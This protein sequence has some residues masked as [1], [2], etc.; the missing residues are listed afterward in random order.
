MNFQLTRHSDNKLYLGIIEAKIEE[1]YG[2][3]LICV[4]PYSVKSL[5]KAVLDKAKIL[6]ANAYEFCGAKL[7]DWSGEYCGSYSFYKIDKP[8]LKKRRDGQFEFNFT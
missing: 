4:N 7:L 8:N 3:S 2:A 1:S 5:E 6:G